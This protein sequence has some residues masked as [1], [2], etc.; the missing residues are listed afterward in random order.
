MEGRVKTI[1][2]LKTEL[3]ELF[4]GYGVDVSIKPATWVE[5]GTITVRC[6]GKEDILFFNAGNS[7]GA[8]L[9]ALMRAAVTDTLAI[10]RR[11]YP[12]RADEKR[13]TDI[14]QFTLKVAA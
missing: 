10:V 3:T 11:E 4:R 5:A 8:S 14:E 6:N 2:D 13:L 12:E 9:K 1:H 7:I